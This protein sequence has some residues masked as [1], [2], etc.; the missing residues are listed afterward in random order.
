[1]PSGSERTDGRRSAC[2][3]SVQYTAIY[4]WWLANVVRECG[5][6]IHEQLEPR[7]CADCVYTCNIITY[8]QSSF[9]R[10][11]NKRNEY[12]GVRKK[13]GT[14]FLG[15]RNTILAGGEKKEETGP[16][17]LKYRMCDGKWVMMHVA[18]MCMVCNTAQEQ[19]HR[20][21]AVAGLLHRIN[22]CCCVL[23]PSF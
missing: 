11:R 9:K 4:G 23:P 2:P 8:T 13:R 22:C 14:R 19:M 17:R 6:Y 1:M 5:L 15:V 10:N 16:R 20:A 12:L 21:H 3:A 7:G 18:C